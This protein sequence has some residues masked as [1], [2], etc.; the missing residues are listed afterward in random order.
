MIIARRLVKLEEIRAARALVPEGVDWWAQ[1]PGPV[2]AY[3]IA[4]EPAIAE[5]FLAH[6]DGML[7]LPGNQDGFRYYQVLTRPWR[8]GARRFVAPA[9][10]VWDLVFAR[11]GA[12]TLGEAQVRVLAAGYHNLLDARRE[13]TTGEPTPRHVREAAAAWA[14]EQAAA[15]AALA[16]EPLCAQPNCLCFAPHGY[17]PRC[18]DPDGA[19]AAWRAMGT[20]APAT[21]AAL[22]FGEL[23]LAL[24]GLADSGQRGISEEGDDAA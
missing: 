7:A 20:N 21:L 1:V 6:L 12:L 24:L 18:G 23:E 17:L 19:V 8:P 15:W 16:G 14:R 11:Q 2:R 5:A 10:M 3:L 9:M 22:G 4:Q 13:A